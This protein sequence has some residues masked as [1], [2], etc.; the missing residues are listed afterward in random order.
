[1]PVRG[2]MSSENN[3]TQF[4][5]VIKRSNSLQASSRRPTMASASA[6]QNEQIEKALVVSPKSSL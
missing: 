1:M 6:H 5:C 4:A 3:P 2:S